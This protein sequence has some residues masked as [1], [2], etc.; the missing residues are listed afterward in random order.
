MYYTDM[1]ICDGLG[2]VGVENILIFKLIELELTD[3]QIQPLMVK[4]F[5]ETMNIQPACLDSVLYLY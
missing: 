4:D 2:L 3:T 5:T 1:K